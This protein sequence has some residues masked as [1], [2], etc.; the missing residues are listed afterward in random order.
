MISGKQFNE[1]YPNTLFVKLT[2][3]QSLHNGY[4]Y[5]NGLNILDGDFNEENICAKGGLY[6]CAYNDFGKWVNYREMKMEYMWTVKIPDDAK[7]VVMDE[8]IKTDKFILSDKKE[9]WTNKE[10]CLEAVKQ[11]GRAL[12]YVKNQT[13]AICL[14]AV[15]KNPG[16]KI[17]IKIKLTNHNKN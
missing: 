3:K 9:I 16:A 12:K 1:K 17:Y 4:Q 11:N 15:K 7:V 10:L 2:N 14:E 6:F 8:K 5:K 13:E